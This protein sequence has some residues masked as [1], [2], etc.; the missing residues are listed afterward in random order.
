MK[1][2]T[3]IATEQEKLLGEKDQELEKTRQELAQTKDKLRETTDKVC[4]VKTL[5]VLYDG[6]P[7]FLCGT[8]PMFICSLYEYIPAENVI[9]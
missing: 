7:W 5:H 1:L 9:L 4:L 2:R 3:Q 6:G 8:A